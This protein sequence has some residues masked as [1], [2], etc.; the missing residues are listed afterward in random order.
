MSDR[1][2]HELGI[3]NRR[4]WDE[5]SAVAESIRRLLGDAQRQSGLSRPSGPGERHE[6]RLLK[7][8]LPFGDLALAADEARRLRRQ[9]RRGAIECPKRRKGGNAPADHE[10]VEGLR[11]R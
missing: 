2:W 1:R 4:E 8:S 6:S 11:R 9:E 10:L 5:E 3:S 7:E